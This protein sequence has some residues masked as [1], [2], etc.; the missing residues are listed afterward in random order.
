M[1]GVLKDEEIKFFKENQDQIT[2]ELLGI[3]R[4][5]GND[6]KRGALAI[7]E[8]RQNEKGFF[9]D[10]FGSPISFDGNKG[11]KKAGTKMPITE[12]HLKEIER[13][14]IDFNY[15]RENYIQIMTPQGV[16]FPEMRDYQQR[17]I[18]A[19]LEDDNEEVVGLI[20]RQCVSGS[21]ILNMEDRDCIIEE[22]FNNPELFGEPQN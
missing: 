6:G 14:A 16:D 8:T 13:C 3:L 5:Q 18:D 21:T 4:Q 2:P 10:V 19:M 17:L 22:L 1:P 11:L 15:F 12:I 20:G 7:L 9:L